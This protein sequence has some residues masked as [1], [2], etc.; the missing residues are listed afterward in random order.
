MEFSF[1]K[2]ALLFCQ[3]L[4]SLDMYSVFCF[5]LVDSGLGVLR[6]GPSSSY[7]PHM[8]A[9]SDLGFFQNAKKVRLIFFNSRQL[10]GSGDICPQIKYIYFL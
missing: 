4:E 2:V 5:S 1:H 9:K 3:L 8:F 10:F 7:F 6:S